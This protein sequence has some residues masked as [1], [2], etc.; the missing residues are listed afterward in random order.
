MTTASPAQPMTYKHKTKDGREVDAVV[1]NG[2][3]FEVLSIEHSPQGVL[4]CIRRPNGVKSY[5][6]RPIT[7]T[8]YG[9]CRAYIVTPLGRTA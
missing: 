9:G 7:D 1:V 6:A 3:V 5:A 2:T 4:L 8:T